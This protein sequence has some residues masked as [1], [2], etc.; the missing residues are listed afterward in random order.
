M[1]PA[2]LRTIVAALA[3]WIIGAHFAAA[4][5]VASLGQPITDPAEITHHMAGNTLTGVLKETGEHWA[6]YYCDTGR[7]LYAFGGINL[8]K[9]WTE[10]GRVCFS[11]EYNDYQDP[12][13]FDMYGKPDGSLAF[14]TRDRGGTMTFVSEPPVPGDP[15]HLEE[16]AL[17]GCALEPSV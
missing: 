4:D 9:W 1:R 7:S 12:I 15:F 14:F 2:M 3:V 13:C 8:G 16:R 17:H 5:D 6:E 11:Y 10:S